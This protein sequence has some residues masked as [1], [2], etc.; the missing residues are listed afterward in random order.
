MVS[1]E[2]RQL[3]HESAGHGVDSGAVVTFWSHFPG[4][5]RC[6]RVGR[7]AIV[8]R[9]D[10]LVDPHRDCD[11]G[12]AETLGHDLQ[13]DTRPQHHARCGVAGVVETDGPDPGPFDGLPPPSRHRLGVRRPTEFVD[14]HEPRVLPRP[15]RCTHCTG[16][17]S[18]LLAP[19]DLPDHIVA[20]DA[21]E[22]AM[23]LKHRENGAE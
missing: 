23:V 8:G 9:R 1:K 19:F 11:V 5:R 17:I 4:E 14:E 3:H 22:L 12:V 13:R 2:C 7:L 20:V 21:D 15:S 10:V 6:E 18:P 16:T